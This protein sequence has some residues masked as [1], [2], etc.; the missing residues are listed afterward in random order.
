MAQHE[1]FQLKVTI[2]QFQIDNKKLENP[3]NEWKLVAEYSKSITVKYYRV[4]N[5]I[6][7][8]LEEVKSGLSH[9]CTE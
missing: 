1:V 5:R 8:A 3:I 6:F 7:T 9:R 4:M 2:Q